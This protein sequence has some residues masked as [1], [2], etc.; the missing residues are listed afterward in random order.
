MMVFTRVVLD[1]Q[2]VPLMLIAL[3]LI[4]FARVVITRVDQ[5]ICPAQRIPLVP[6]LHHS[7]AIM[8][9]IAMQLLASLAQ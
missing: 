2:S 4:S 1:A 7:R 9:S 3:K 8:D 5:H 6:Q